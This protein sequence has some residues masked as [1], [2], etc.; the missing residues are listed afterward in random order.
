MRLETRISFSLRIRLVANWIRG[1]SFGRHDE[2]RLTGNFPDYERVPPQDNTNIARLVKDEIKGAIGR[3]AQFADERS[4]AIRV[5]FTA[6]EVRIF[7]SALETGESEESVPGECSG[8]DLE[9]G[10][11][12]LS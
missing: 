4:R 5:Q 8:P 9:M 12:Y 10:F 2:T 1:D 3:V 7:S 11:N 6:G